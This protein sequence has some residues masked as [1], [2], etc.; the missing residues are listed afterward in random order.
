VT[1]VRHTLTSPRFDLSHANEAA[2]SEG[3]FRSSLPKIDIDENVQGATPSHSIIQSGFVLSYLEMLQ[4]VVMS[5]VREESDPTH[6]R[7]SV[8]ILDRLRFRWDAIAGL[9]GDVKTLDTSHK[10]DFQGVYVHD[11]HVRARGHRI[12]F[13]ITSSK[14][15][16][17]V[18][19]LRW[20]SNTG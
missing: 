5:C 11:V 3:E 14:R 9:V 7:L 13:R 2:D 16:P 18:A 17:P 4:I 1:W 8:Y 19:G 6:R 10:T 20:P 12:P 15:C